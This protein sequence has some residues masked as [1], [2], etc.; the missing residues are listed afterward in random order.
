MSEFNKIE[1]RIHH[2]CRA[3]ALHRGAPRRRAG[4]PPHS[5]LRLLP[6]RHR[7]LPGL[8]PLQ[9][10]APCRRP[11]GPPR[12]LLLPFRLGLGIVAGSFARPRRLARRPRS[13]LSK[14]VLLLLL[15]PHHRGLLAVA[16][17]R[18]APRR[19]ESLRREHRAVLHERL[20]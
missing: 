20:L 5:G 14:C 18:C 15:L 2:L 8:L 7:R 9:R 19:G 16:G 1:A 3:V 11:R 4:G 13:G 12:R 10:R 17:D 6:P